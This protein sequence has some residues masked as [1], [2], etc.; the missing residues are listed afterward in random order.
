MITAKPLAGPHHYLVRLTGTYEP[1][2]TASAR[3]TITNQASPH[4]AEALRRTRP[5]SRSQ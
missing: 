4:H 1:P 5:P 3:T 2:A